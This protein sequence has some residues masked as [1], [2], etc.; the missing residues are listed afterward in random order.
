V[1]FNERQ[2]DEC[3]RIVNLFRDK[4]SQH[5]KVLGV[6]ACNLA[7][8]LGS[9]GTTIIR[10]Y[11]K[12]SATQARIDYDFFSTLNV[13]FIQGRDFS[14]DHADDRKNGAIVNQALVKELGI[15]SPIGKT[16]GDPSKGYPSNLN[17]IGV[18]NDFNVYSLHREILPAVFSMQPKNRY[19]MMMIR[20][21]DH[22]ISNTISYLKEVWSEIAPGKL[23][24][25]SCVSEDLEN[26]Y[27]NEK[28]WTGIIQCSSI[29]AIVI[30]CLGIFG[31]SKLI[32]FRKVK[33]IGVRKVL[34]AKEIQ[35]I[36]L[37]LKE[38]IFLVVAANIIAWPVAWFAM[39]KWL[40]NYAYR[41]NLSI[42]IFLLSG[43][44]A[45][46]IALITVSYQTIKA[47]R[48]NPVESLRY[49]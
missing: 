47:A 10:D 25:F 35:I 6:T 32:A 2:N 36:S 14:K 33:E 37:I 12:Y 7:M 23:F 49:E 4:T 34:G 18:V 5:P 29:L 16:I 20:I 3:L 24:D 21:S 1:A 28:R 13:E 26:H 44:A 30:A 17:I 42:W 22:N 41:T 48:A 27:D 19:Q 39:D 46:A 15:D 8:G 43:L 11:Q 38:F 40:Q 31:L 45:L 9:N